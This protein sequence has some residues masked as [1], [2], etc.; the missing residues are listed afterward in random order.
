VSA[1]FV[2]EVENLFVLTIQG[3][4]KFEDLK[5]IERDARER[6]DRTSRVRFLV[7]A[8]QFSGW[9]KEGDWGDLAFMYEFNPLIE[10]IA[11]VA[12]ETWKPELLMFLG[13]ENRQAEVLFF[14]ADQENA[15]RDWLLSVKE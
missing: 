1:T 13:G 6:I 2:Q 5:A 8:G 11:V 9:G 12:N 10:R 3:V 15:A 7:L 14:A 4:F